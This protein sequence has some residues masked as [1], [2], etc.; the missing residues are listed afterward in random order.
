[1]YNDI[2]NRSILLLNITK[3]KFNKGLVHKKR[4]NFENSGLNW[5]KLG[6]FVDTHHILHVIDSMFG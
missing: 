5:S 1:M 6:S 3:S 4:E 2:E